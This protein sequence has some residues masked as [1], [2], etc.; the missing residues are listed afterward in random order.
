M[1]RQQS[2]SHTF[3]SL[4]NN[5]PK[6]W[7]DDEDEH[8]DDADDDVDDDDCGCCIHDR[9]LLSASQFIE[10]SVDSSPMI[11]METNRKMRLFHCDSLSADA[12]DINVSLFRSSSS[13]RN[14]TI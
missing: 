13:C 5:S 9:A 10:P 4:C 6:L 14:F 12:E 3:T 1:F 8:D 11:M 2:D 7:Y